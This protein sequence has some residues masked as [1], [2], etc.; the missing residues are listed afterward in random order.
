MLNVPNAKPRVIAAMF[1]EKVG[2]F[3]LGV[4]VRRRAIARG[5]RNEQNMVLII[6]VSTD[7]EMIVWISWRY[8]VKAVGSAVTLGDDML[9]VDN[10]Y[11]LQCY[12]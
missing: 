4:L 2:V 8:G 7:E 11:P 9:A 6:R 3:H 12:V 10:G 5:T 1:M